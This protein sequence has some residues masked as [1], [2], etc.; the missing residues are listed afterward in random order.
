VSPWWWAL[1]AL[2][3]AGAIGSWLWLRH[4]AAAAD[5]AA[6]A[7]GDADGPATD[8]GP[9]GHAPPDDEDDWPS[10]PVLDPET[11]GS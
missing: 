7:Q 1:L 6:S 3:V 4:R 10:F 8:P 9:D 2:V 5:E 11:T